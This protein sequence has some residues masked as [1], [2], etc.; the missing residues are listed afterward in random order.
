MDLEQP[1]A[2]KGYSLQREKTQRPH[3][4]INESP[5]AMI[6]NLRGHSYPAMTDLEHKRN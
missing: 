2:L 4:R 3:K 6:K 1:L 5:P